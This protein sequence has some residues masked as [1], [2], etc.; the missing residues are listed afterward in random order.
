MQKLSFPFLK[1]LIHSEV[2]TATRNSGRNFRTKFI[3][4]EPCAGFDGSAGSFFCYQSTADIQD[5]FSSCAARS[6]RKS[7]HRIGAHTHYGAGN[8]GNLM[9][10]PI[11]FLSS[12]ICTPVSCRARH[13]PRR[14]TQKRDN[15]VL[16][17]DLFEEIFQNALRHIF[18]Y[19][20]VIHSLISEPP[21]LRLRLL[22]QL[23]VVSLWIRKL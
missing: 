6:T 15:T 19:S 22:D 23:T 4:E 2:H 3:R 21:R 11:L 9:L 7:H 16:I 12:F 1:T 13:A 5:S 8:T 17:H 14:A 20:I 18:F 10:F